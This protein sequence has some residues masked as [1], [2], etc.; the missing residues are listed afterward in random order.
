MVISTYKA[1]RLVEVI[2][3]THLIPLRGVSKCQASSLT[4][5][6]DF[7]QL[8]IL[9]FSPSFFIPVSRFPVQSL[10]GNIFL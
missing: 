1:V 5:N 8:F 2:I 10:V 6:V 9:L 7:D 3:Y 4:P